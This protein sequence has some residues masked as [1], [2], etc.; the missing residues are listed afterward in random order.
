MSNPTVPP[1]LGARGPRWFA[2]DSFWNQPLADTATSDPQSP[3]WIELLTAAH[4]A[5]PT[6]GEAGLHLN[7]NAWTLP[8]YYADASTPRRTL[9][10]KL[11][12]CRYSQG[13]LLVSR[14]YLHDAHPLGLHASVA[15]GVPI[16]AA[17][18]TDAEA[19][20]HLVIVAPQE[21]R[22]YDLWQCRPEADGSW[23]TNA[24]ISYPLDGPGV[25]TAETIAGIH[26]DESV[27]FYGPCRAPGVPACAGLIR[28]D[29]LLAGEIAH[30]LAFACEVAALQEFIAPAI[31]TDGWLPGGLPEGCILQ[32]DPALNLDQFNLTPAARTIARALQRYGAVLVDNAGGVTL[33]GEWLG[34]AETSGW[35]GLL[36]ENDLFPI[37]FQHYRILLTGP[38]THAGSHPVYHHEM[39]AK[40][41]AHLRRHGIANSRA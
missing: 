28:R 7:L 32:L 36:G 6:R 3:R 13:H 41:Y 37:P 11:P 12:E 16:P 40:Y 2:P 26:N 25:F 10:P 30:K 35:N 34:P 38:V 8:I 31:W 29:E 23:S 22:I 17:A 14:P 18:C 20:A 39:S 19:D 27:H 15:D 33:Y 24:A 1:Q 9:R 4:T 5:D 21:N